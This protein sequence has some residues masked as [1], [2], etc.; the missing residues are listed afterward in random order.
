[1]GIHAHEPFAFEGVGFQRSTTTA[2]Q[3]P[4]G[5]R[6]QVVFIGVLLRQ[7]DGLPWIKPPTKKTPMGL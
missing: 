2:R 6:F 1:M 5:S 3:F 7:I 4:P